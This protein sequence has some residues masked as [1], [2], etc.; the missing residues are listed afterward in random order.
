MGCGGEAAFALRARNA[1][2]SPA[3]ER[4]RRVRVLFINDTARNGG[5]GRS[6][7]A[8]LR[9]LD[10]EA[11]HRT[12]L[13]PRPGA[14]SELLASGGA[15]DALL[16]EPAW[17]ENIV[18][19]WRRSMERADFAAPRVLRWLRACGN[20]GRMGAAIART[21]ALVRR[22]RYDLIYCN[23]TTADFVGGLV[24]NLT[25]VPALWHVRYTSL[26][27][28]AAPLHRWLAGSAAVRRIV[29]VSSA[30]AGVVAHCP[31]KVSIIN[32]G[33]D[34]DAFAPG[35]A[36]PCLRAELGLPAD[37]VVFGSH[38]RVLRRKGYLELVRAACVA[39]GRMTRAER[40]RCHFVVV[41]DTPQDFQPDHVEEC[42]ALAAQ[43]GV[44]GSVSF[45]G[46]RADVRP[47]I[48][49]WDVSV[50]PSVYPDPL[51]RAVI[52]S[53]A[54][55]KPVIAFDVGG[56][57]EMLTPAEGTLLPRPPEIADLAAAFLR[58]LRDPAL[59]ARQGLAGRRRVVREF[60]ASAHAARIEGEILA[61]AD[62]AEADLVP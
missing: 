60:S 20:V 31:D 48:A 56:V 41:G 27:G 8:I 2:V 11:V 35:A 55:G 45:L 42:R 36:A 39:L 33:V 23:G 25:G 54:L 14:V 44:A 62:G 4:R 28:A 19:P 18:E 47:Y 46:F 12:V 50:V 16:F 6:L 58:Y 10:P 17:V 29:C 59:R 49:D 32:N 38:G 26:P 40:A 51:P 43:L 53:M 34:T 57:R 22:E 37:A 9:H 15:A 3:P 21:A 5:P 52:E 24:A 1:V 13:L 30:A 61:A 7:H